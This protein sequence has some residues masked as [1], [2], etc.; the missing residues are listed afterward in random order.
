MEKGEIA[1][2]EQFHL[3]P[4]CF[5]EVFFFDVLKRVYMEERVKFTKRTMLC[6]NGISEVDSLS[7]C[8]DH[9]SIHQAQLVVPR[10]HYSP[11][12]WMGEC[13]TI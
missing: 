8:V 3:F 4:Q 13:N 10:Q 2:F 1:H 12:I 6:Y 9:K 7:M 5:P 11:T